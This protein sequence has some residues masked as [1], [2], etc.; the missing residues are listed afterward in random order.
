MNPPDE[1]PPAYY[2]SPAGQGSQNFDYSGPEPPAYPPPPGLSHDISSGANATH[3]DS[4]NAAA[5]CRAYPLTAPVKLRADQL[6]A[7][8]SLY[9][10][11]LTP[12]NFQGS[13]RLLN[14]TSRSWLV[15]SLPGCKDTLVQTALPSYSAIADSP[16]VTERAKTIYFEVRVIRLGERMPHSN[17][18][19]LGGIFSHTKD[20]PEERG[21]ALGFF[22]PPYPPFRL[23]GWQRGSLGVHSDDGRR[24]IGNTDGGVDFTA[25]F[26]VGETLGLG[27]TFAL[28]QYSQT[29]PNIEA[30][31]FF[32][33]DGRK[34]GGWSL[35]RETDAV[36][37]SIVGLMGENDLFPSIGVFG[38]VEVEVNFGERDWLYRG[39]NSTA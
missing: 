22:A 26:K 8:H 25:P 34:A 27:I 13:L 11:L 32:T 16:L 5:W 33:R 18:S 17:R 31:V 10:T 29:G 35:V 1:P 36:A 9:H 4:D 24:Y 2:P 30:E 39:W 15:E 20:S 6:Q 7:I 37:E 12:P 28:A 21:V 3:F 19:K 38:P 23:P 14:A